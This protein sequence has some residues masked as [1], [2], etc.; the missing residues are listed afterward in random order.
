LQAIEQEALDLATHQDRDL[1]D[2]LHQRDRLSDRLWPGPRR[3]H[4]LDDGHK[5]GR[6]DRVGDKKTFTV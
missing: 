4:D 3:W 1:T 5:I 2:I 6:I